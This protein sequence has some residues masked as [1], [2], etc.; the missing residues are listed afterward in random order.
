VIGQCGGVEPQRPPPDA[1]GVLEREPRELGLRRRERHLGDFQRGRCAA[2]LEQ[3]M[4]DGLGG[5]A[6]LEADLRRA[7]VQRLAPGGQ[8]L[9]VEAVAQEDVGESERL[10]SL[11][12]HDD[13]GGQG[14]VQR[15][16]H[17]I[18][19]GARGGGE[20]AAREVAPEYGGDVEQGARFRRDSP[21]SFVEHTGTH[22]PRAGRVRTRA[23]P[24]H[25][26]DEQGMA[27][28][29]SIELL[30]ASCAD[31]RHGLARPGRDRI[32]REPS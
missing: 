30:D 21:E 8:Q 15:R 18:G 12:R 11:A 29:D 26:D 10:G 25:F 1:R 13:A 7:M 6:A 22:R 3:M 19:G 31:A 17:A 5:R 28:G 2:R 23:E 9:R 14:F 24:E 27:L 4:H 16:E 20:V 32:G